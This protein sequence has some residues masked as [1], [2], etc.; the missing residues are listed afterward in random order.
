MSPGKLLSDLVPELIFAI[1]SSCDISSV[2]ATGQVD[3]YFPS[4]LS[5]KIICSL[6][7]CR[8]LHEV[9]FDKS[10]W[11]DLLENLRRRSLLDRVFTPNLE[12]LVMGEMLQLVKRMTTGPETWTA[13]NGHFV[14][15]VCKEIALHPPELTRSSRYEAKLL[16]SGRF[17]VFNNNNTIECWSVLDSRPIWRH[18]LAAAGH[19]LENFAADETDSEDSVNIMLCVAT[20][21]WK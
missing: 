11:L 13:E 16:P 6:Q 17:I 18:R 3:P 14:A 7:T 2:V 9:A 10:V 8:Y 12:T 4:C 1:F 5:P 21:H 19:R 15:E 20:P